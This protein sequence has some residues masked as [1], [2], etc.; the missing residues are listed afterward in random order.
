M[1]F[2]RSLSRFTCYLSNLSIFLI[3]SWR[4]S[5]TLIWFYYILLSKDCFKA[6]SISYSILFLS[7]E[8]R[9][10]SITCLSLAYRVSFSSMRT[11]YSCSCLCFFSFDSKSCN[12]ANS[13]LISVI[14]A[15]YAAT[16]SG[17]LMRLGSL[18]L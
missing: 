8:V 15:S 10:E 12:L 9:P 3:S 13:P 4:T 18:F 6:Y 14:L 1:R 16:I 2:S 7:S 11:L 5:S 17:C